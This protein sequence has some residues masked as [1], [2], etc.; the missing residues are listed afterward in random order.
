MRFSNFFRRGS[1][2]GK[3][4]AP[5]EPA[6][7]SPWEADNQETLTQLARFVDFAEGFTLGF[8]ELN[9]SRDLDSVMT[10]LRRRLE[11]GGVSFHIFT[12]NDP[13]L[14]FLKDALEAKIQQL[15]LTPAMLRSQKRL[16]VVDGLENAIGLFGEYPPLLQDL[17]FVRDAWVESIPYPVLFCLPSYAINRV[18]Q[19]APDFWSWQSGVFRI[20]ASQER[21]DDASI[22]A[23][24]AQT[25]LG[26]ASKLERQER[27]KLLE[28]LA[29][30]FD[31]LQGTRNKADLRIAAEA[32][33]ELGIVYQ[34]SG[35][36]TRAE[37]SLALAAQVFALAAWPPET[38]RDL[39]LRIKY[40][41]WHGYLAYKLGQPSLAEKRLQT[42]LRLN[43]NVDDGLRATAYQYLANLKANQGDVGGAIALYQQSLDIQERIG[44]ALGK[45]ATLH[46]MAILKANQGDVGGAIALF[47]QSLDIQERIG[48]AQGKA[49]TLAMLGQLLADK[50]GDFATAIPYLEESLAILQR[51]GSPDAAT[52]RDILDRVQAIAANA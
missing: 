34:F 48:N 47:Q 38:K 39:T 15:P 37:A 30:E 44:D 27:I 11:C 46:Q 10:A 2:G 21:M 14:R 12:L 31:P 4:I 42:S 1:R 50:Q 7:I 24:H 41:T 35:E 45:A 19:F 26:N 20:A 43:S 18:I 9:F 51:I 13:N 17:N 40:L 33:T 22:Y 28:S 52:V 6:Q 8:L 32:L 49:A 25:A 16:I 29:Q 36:L 23:L 5:P 3:A